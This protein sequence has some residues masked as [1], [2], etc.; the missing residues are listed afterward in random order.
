VACERKLRT[1]IIYKPAYGKF[2]RFAVISW[3]T[4]SPSTGN[5]DVCILVTHAR[6]EHFVNILANEQSVSLLSRRKVQL[7][8]RRTLVVDQFSIKKFF[9]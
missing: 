5:N 3:S 8:I 6:V 9:Q 7:S 2:D 1:Q 4:L